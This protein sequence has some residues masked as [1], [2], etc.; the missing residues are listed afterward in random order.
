[1]NLHGREL[2]RRKDGKVIF[3]VCA[4]LGDYFDVDPNLIRLAAIL[5]GCTGTGIIVYLAAAIILPEY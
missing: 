2:Y 1:M 4:G 3:G 5:V